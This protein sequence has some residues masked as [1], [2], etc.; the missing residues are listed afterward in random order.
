MTGPT[1][2][3]S[4]GTQYGFLGFLDENNRLLGGT[5][6]APTNGDASG[7]PLD[8][9]LGVQEA[10]PATPDPDTVASPGDDINIAEWELDSLATRRFNISIATYDLDQVAQIQ[11][12]SVASRADGK[13]GV[14]DI[15]E[16]PDGDGVIILQGRTKKQDIGVKGKKAWSGVLLPLVGLSWLGRQ[17]FTSREAAVYRYSVTP[18]LASHEP[19]GLTIA[20]YY[21][22]DAARRIAFSYDNPIHLHT[23]RGD[24]VE[25]TFVVK[26]RPISTAKVFAVTRIPGGGA[27]VATVSSVTP[28]THEVVLNAAPAAGANVDIWYQFDQF[29]E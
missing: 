23:F 12:T 18:Q 1:R 4:M 22:A 28:S 3:A 21:D 5:R 29:V 8:H 27:V 9:I 15:S 25:T 6:T 26:H 13:M 16:V 19:W 14:E 7:S 11:N 24:G 2:G 20:D 10:A 17:S